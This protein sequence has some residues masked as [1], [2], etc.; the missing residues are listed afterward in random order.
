[1]S[2]LLE[3]A[4]GPASLRVAYVLSIVVALLIGLLAVW[5]GAYIVLAFCA[6]FIFLNVQG[7]VRW[8][9]PPLLRWTR[10]IDPR[11]S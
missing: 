6:F 10:E 7:S 2:A 8:R 5:G 9:G 3:L 4:F 1:M 11:E